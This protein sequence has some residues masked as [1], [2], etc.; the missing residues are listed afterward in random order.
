[1]DSAKEQAT[2]TKWKQLDAEGALMSHRH[3]ESSG[4]PRPH[5]RRKTKDP[6]TFCM[7]GAIRLASLCLSIIHHVQ[8]SEYA[9]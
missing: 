7:L 2:W 1:M 9:A 5:S 6:A 4:R 8:E 3:L